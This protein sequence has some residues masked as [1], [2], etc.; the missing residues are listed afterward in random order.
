MVEITIFT[1]S[2]ATFQDLKL[3]ITLSKDQTLNFSRSDDFFAQ[4]LFCYLGRPR[5][6]T[7]KAQS[8][9]LYQKNQE[10]P[11]TKNQG[12]PTLTPPPQ[13]HHTHT[14]SLKYSVT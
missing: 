12:T 3:T 5:S 1:F 6:D 4:A 7:F 2:R 14:H 11:F 13:P 9:T 10:K 8:F